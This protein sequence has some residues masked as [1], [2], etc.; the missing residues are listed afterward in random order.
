MNDIEICKRIAKICGLPEPV[1]AHN[2]PWVIVANPL[3]DR[4]L[5]FD[6]MVEQGINLTSIDS[7]YDCG[8]VERKYICFEQ[9]AYP[10]NIANTLSTDAD[11]QRAICLAIINKDN[12]Q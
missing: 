3:T 9:G 2:G 6:L 5:S 10:L 1:Q 4:A 11:P 12:K 7:V 8:R